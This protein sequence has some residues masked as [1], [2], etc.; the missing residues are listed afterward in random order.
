[1]GRFIFTVSAF[2]FP[3]E[4]ST[5]KEGTRKSI[6]EDV[7]L[8][9]SSMNPPPKNSR[10]GPNI[11]FVCFFFKKRRSPVGLLIN[12]STVSTNRLSSFFCS[13]FRRF[14]PRENWSTVTHYF[15]LWRLYQ[16]LPSLTRWNLVFSEFAVGFIGVYRVLWVF[17]RVCTGFNLGFT[18]FCY[19]MNVA[20]YRDIFWEKVASL[21]L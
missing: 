20:V 4:K 17:Y 16:V 10:A 15:S 6:L 7:F 8:L 5:V 9:F 21:S 14:N 3:I 13:G 12:V 18:G 1:M 2:S 11:F 19:E